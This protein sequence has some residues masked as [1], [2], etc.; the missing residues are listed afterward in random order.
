MQAA[1]ARFWRGSA[2]ARARGVATF[3]RMADDV[4]EINADELKARVGELRRY[5]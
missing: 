1:A 3:P 2:L 4:Q 5:L